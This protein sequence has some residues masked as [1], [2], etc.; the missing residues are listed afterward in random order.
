[1]EPSP[2][3]F[4]SYVKLVKNLRGVVLFDPKDKS[5][6]EGIGWLSSRFRY[7][8]LGVPPMLAS[9]LPEKLFRGRVFRRLFYPVEPLAELPFIMMRTGVPNYFAE[10]IVLSSVY[11]SPI[12]LISRS[13]EDA[14]S[15]GCLGM[16]KVCGGLSVKDWKLH[17]RIAGY[18]IID[19]YEDMID[20]SLE[21]IRGSKNDGKEIIEKRMGIVINDAKR[22]WRI[23]CGENETPLDVFIYYYDPL[24]PMV[25]HGLRK[26]LKPEHAPGLSVVPVV[27]VGSVISS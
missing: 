23:S 17:V 19:F 13:L 25:K 9:R 22:Y 18:S 15:K 8:N 21:Y 11:I 6:L 10:A 16:V 4:T 24:K 14:L 3:L 27:N 26:L 20:L 1:M 2:V 7:R 12:L 5:Y